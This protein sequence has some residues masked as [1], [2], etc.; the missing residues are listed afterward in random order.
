MY[1]PIHCALFGIKII[2]VTPQWFSLP[3]VTA[4]RETCSFFCT[5]PLCTN[6]PS[7]T[8]IHNLLPFS[9]LKVQLTGTGTFP[10]TWWY[11]WHHCSVYLRCVIG[12]LAVLQWPLLVKWQLSCFFQ[13][14][15]GPDGPTGEMGL[16]G[17]AVRNLAVIQSIYWNFLVDI[18]S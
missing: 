17:K 15:I 9:T 14:A 13:G 12:C 7:H 8:L 11:Y 16:Q 10:L 1:L 18:Q 5:F 4:Y 2:Q 6:S 3:W